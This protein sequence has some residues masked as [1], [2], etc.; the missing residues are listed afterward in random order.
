MENNKKENKIL[1]TVLREIKEGKLSMKPKWHFIVKTI[2]GVLA[3]FLSLSILLYIT[4][5]VSFAIKTNG[6]VFAP[7]FGFRGIGIFLMA[8]PWL[9]ILVGVISIVLVESLIRRYSFGYKKPIV[10][11]LLVIL[12]LIVFGNLIDD[13]LKFHERF[14]NYAG[15]RGV[16]MFKLFYSNFLDKEQWEIHMGL[17]STSTNGGFILE[18]RNEGN[19]NIQINPDTKIQPGLELI[20]DIA[21]VVFGE[22]VENTVQAIGVK[23]IGDRNNMPYRMMFSRPRQADVINY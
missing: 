7:E 16:P 22:R 2:F 12:V 14:S 20:N 5:F 10:Y 17:I 6:A 11:S 9:L 23:R 4:S 15:R 21:V 13:N 8:V 19:L 3:V 1:N 18:T